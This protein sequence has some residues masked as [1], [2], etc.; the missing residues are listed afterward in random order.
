MGALLHCLH[1]RQ[2]LPAPIQSHGYRMTLDEFTRHDSGIVSF[3][4]GQF[5]VCWELTSDGP[6]IEGVKINGCYWWAAEVMSSC[7][8]DKLNE[9]LVRELAEEARQYF[10]EPAVTA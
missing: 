2:P 3:D 7:L 1:T 4:G 10:V 5:F 6:N 9:Q 8:L